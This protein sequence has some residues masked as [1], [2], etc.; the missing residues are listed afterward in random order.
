M[1]AG[2]HLLAELA[3]FLTP[4]ILTYGLSAAHIVKLNDDELDDV[5]R[6]FPDAWQNGVWGFM[7]QFGLPG[8]YAGMSRTMLY[9]VHGRPWV[10]SCQSPFR[11]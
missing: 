5:R 2:L 4:E 6:I 1:G 9:S 7:R 8:Y 11:P 3:V 10:P